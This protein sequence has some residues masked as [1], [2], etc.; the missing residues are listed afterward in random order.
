[1]ARRFLRLLTSAAPAAALLCL[2]LAMARFGVDAG[3]AREAIF[4][5]LWASAALLPLSLLSA[6]RPTALRSPTAWAPPAAALAVGLLLAFQERG[7]GSR[8]AWVSLLLVLALTLVATRELRVRSLSRTGVAASLAIAAAI[9]VYGHRLYTAPS[10]PLTWLFLILLPALA[11]AVAA[12]LARRRRSPTAALVGAMLLLAPLVATES[13]WCLAVLAVLAVLSRVRACRRALAAAAVLA[14]VAGSFPWLRPRPVSTLVG[15]ALSF[16]TPITVDALAGRSVVLSAARPLVDLEI[17][18]SAIRGLALDSYLT[19][20]SGLPCGAP[21]ATVALSGDGVLFER[22]LRIGE[23]SAEWA[24]GR[25]DVSLACAAPPTWIHWVPRDGRFFGRTTRT[26]IS[27]ESG[28]AAK[29]VRIAR[30][31]SLPSDVTL[32]IFRVGLER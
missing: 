32:A 31:P 19:N 1:M 22:T 14:L 26:A 13:W 10:A 28:L 7:E 30:D 16:A 12:A 8:A 29:A 20:S 4:L 21:L 18:E 24:A 15:E 25:P 6:V 27:F 17:R 3:A 11:G 23:D 5:A 9:V 2:S